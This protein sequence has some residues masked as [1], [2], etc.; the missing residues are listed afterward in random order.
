MAAIVA[1]K[2][3]ARAMLVIHPL[4]ADGEKVFLG[5]RQHGVV[6]HAISKRK[7]GDSW[8]D[9]AAAV[10]LEGPDARRAAHRGV[11][12]PHQVGLGLGK[13]FVREAMLP[14]RLQD[15]VV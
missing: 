4:V 6:E 9:S 15:I 8:P 10:E 13:E 5:A 7:A 14:G 3:V 2:S 1:R 12:L 11:A